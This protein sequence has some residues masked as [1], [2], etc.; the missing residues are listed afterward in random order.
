METPDAITEAVERTTSASGV[1]QRVSDPHALQTVAL[2]LGVNDEP[3]GDLPEAIA[4]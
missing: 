4:G 2:M 3:G 1:P